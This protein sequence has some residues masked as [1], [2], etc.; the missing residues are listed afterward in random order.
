MTNNGSPR[1]AHSCRPEQGR[2]LH[3]LLRI[4]AVPAVE[5]ELREL[6][7]SMRDSRAVRR[8]KSDY[9]ICVCRVLKKTRVCSRGIISRRFLVFVHIVSSSFLLLTT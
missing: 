2:G 7:R 5:A 1:S 9:A 3:F 4:L 6:D 8:A